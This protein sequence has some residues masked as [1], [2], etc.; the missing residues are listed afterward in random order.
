MEQ[1]GVQLT[2]AVSCSMCSY[3][4]AGGTEADFYRLL[5]RLQRDKVG[6]L[7]APTHTVATSWMLLICSLSQHFI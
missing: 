7:S 6:L 2:A 5:L 3:V 4:M 1:R